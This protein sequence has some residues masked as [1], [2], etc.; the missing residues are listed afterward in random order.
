MFLDSKFCNR[1]EI[2]WT[3]VDSTVQAF[4][5]LKKSI[6]SEKQCNFLPIFLYFN[7]ILN[8][9]QEYLGLKSSFEKY[10]DENYEVEKSGVEAGFEMPCNLSFKR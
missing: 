7:S 10:G 3:V 5:E 1:P 2:F 4:F 8:F 6:K 9:G